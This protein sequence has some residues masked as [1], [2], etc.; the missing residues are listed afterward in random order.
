MNLA[1]SPQRQ[2]ALHATSGPSSWHAFGLAAGPWFLLFGG[3]GLAA[4]TLGDALW[5]EGVMAAFVAAGI[6]TILLARWRDP[7][8]QTRSLPLALLVGG[9]SGAGLGVVLLLSAMLCWFLTD[10]ASGG[11]WG[12]GRLW[13][14]SL[15]IAQFLGVCGFLLF[16]RQPQRGWELTRRIVLG[17]LGLGLGVGVVLY[18]FYTGP[19]DLATYPPQADSPYRLPWPAGVAHLC[20]Q[21]NRGVVSHR[22][23]GEYSYDF[24]MPVGSDVCA[25]RG[26]IVVQVEDQHDGNGLDLPNNRIVIQHDDRTFGVYAH[27]KQHGSHV[28]PGQRVVQGERLG[29]SGN[30]GFSLSP[31][32]HFHVQEGNRTLPVSFADVPGDGVPRM[33]HRYTSGNTVSGP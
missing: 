20:S 27:L 17:V 33:F 16:R 12:E 9:L 26:G 31:H 6:L 4:K 22:G 19:R 5:S 30:V 25:A 29:A 8:A 1:A 15:L 28:R 21:S 3:V 23:S 10:V 18:A 7:S 13:L 24:A 14:A 32:L 11:R 2:V